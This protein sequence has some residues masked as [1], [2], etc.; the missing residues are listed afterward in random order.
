MLHRLTSFLIS[1]NTFLFVMFL[2]V[3]FSILGTEAFCLLL[4]YYGFAYVTL[5]VDGDFFWNIQNYLSIPILLPVVLVNAGV[6]LFEQYSSVTA[7]DIRIF[8]G[9]V[10]FLVILAAAFRITVYHRT[11]PRDLY[12]PIVG[13]LICG[14]LLY[15]L[16]R[17][18][19]GIIPILSNEENRDY[20]YFSYNPNLSDDVYIFI[21]LLSFYC[22]AVLKELTI[23]R[24]LIRRLTF[25]IL[26]LFLSL[27][28]LYLIQGESRGAWAAVL[29]SCC[30][31]FVV[32][33]VSKR[34]FHFSVTA[35]CTI[36]L[37]VLLKSPTLIQRIS[38]PKE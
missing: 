20:G 32:G 9:P 28:L 5:R 29:V 1:R 2:Q 24:I 37:I 11:N 21:L 22:M 34:R 8:F 6:L 30:L 13:G 35:V 33:L 27:S 19:G 3:T 17:P 38:H 25:A 31:V 36:C 10:V 15:F 4:P 7:F 12:W 18:S 14:S 23:R 26:L 16:L